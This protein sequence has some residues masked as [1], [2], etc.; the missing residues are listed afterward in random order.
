MKFSLKIIILIIFSLCTITSIKIASN[1]INN[2]I[3]VHKFLFMYKYPEVKGD[4]THKLNIMSYKSL[5]LS[6]DEISV[7]ESTNDTIEVN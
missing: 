6:N 2:E 7:F 3:S 1:G 5:I 4:T